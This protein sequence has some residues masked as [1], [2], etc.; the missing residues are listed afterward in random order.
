MALALY[1]WKIMPPHAE[2]DTASTCPGTIKP[3]Y[4]KSRGKWR[5]R[6]AWCCDACGM[7]WFP[8]KNGTWVK[9]LNIATQPPGAEIR[10]TTFTPLSET[11]DT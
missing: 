5:Q 9:G 2:L 11:K 3:T 1:G 7:H 8:R 10:D 4:R 6:L